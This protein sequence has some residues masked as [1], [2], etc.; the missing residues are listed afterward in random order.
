MHVEIPLYVSHYIGWFEKYKK[1]LT[2]KLSNID[3]LGTRHIK[4]EELLGN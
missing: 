1:K 2:I 4:R 3:S